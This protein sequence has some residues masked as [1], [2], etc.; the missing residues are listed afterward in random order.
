MSL[1]EAL[2]KRDVFRKMRALQDKMAIK[3]NR[4]NKIKSKT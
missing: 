1:E 3:A 2:E 4:Q